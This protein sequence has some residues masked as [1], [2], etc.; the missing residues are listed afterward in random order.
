M[1]DAVMLIGAAVLLVGQ[2]VCMFSKKVWVRLLPL[3]VI[4]VLAL[5]CFGLY[6]LSGFTNWGYMI[7]LILL[8]AVTAVSGLIWFCYGFSCLVQKAE[9]YT[10]L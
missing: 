9:D 6:A 10:G 4:G 7:L 5:V 1:E 2:I 3:M 8:G